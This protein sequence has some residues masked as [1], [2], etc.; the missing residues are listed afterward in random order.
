MWL[1][2]D[3]ASAIRYRSPYI[4]KFKMQRPK[5]FSKEEGERKGEREGVREGSRLLA[6]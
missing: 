6:E 5:A 3:K 1:S 2:A 4:T